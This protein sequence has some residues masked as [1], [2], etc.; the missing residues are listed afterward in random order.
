M[1]I[2]DKIEVDITA[3]F[4]E[5]IMESMY[6]IL[7]AMKRSNTYLDANTFEHI[8]NIIF[9]AG[10]TEPNDKEL[11]EYLESFKIT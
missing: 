10:N 2:V 11:T 8:L 4:N 7:N 6:S 3:H 1:A 9:K 5:K